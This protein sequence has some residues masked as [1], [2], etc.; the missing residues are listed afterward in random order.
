MSGGEIPFPWRTGNRAVFAIIRGDA[1]GRQHLSDGTAE[2]Q[3]P[4]RCLILP[5]PTNKMTD[6]R[7]V[8]LKLPAAISRQ[9]LGIA[10]PIGAGY[11]R[12]QLFYGRLDEAVIVLLD[13]QLM[14]QEPV[15][16]GGNLRSQPTGGA[17]HE[18]KD[19]LSRRSG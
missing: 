16:T 7:L 6:L 9:L 5:Q 4:Q 12:T 17:D 2:A 14:A 1:P 10:C 11:A 3:R 18:A 13:Q 19:I 8:I 15:F